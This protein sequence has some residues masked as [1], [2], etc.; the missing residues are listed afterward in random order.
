MDIEGGVPGF[1]LTV[2]NVRTGLLCYNH[3]S[4]FKEHL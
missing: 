3:P 1:H 2:R 4:F